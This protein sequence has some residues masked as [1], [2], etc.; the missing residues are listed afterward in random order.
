[1]KRKLVFSG[2]ML[3]FALVAVVASTYAWL[4]MQAEADVTEMDLNVTSGADLQISADGETFGYNIEIPA[5]GGLLNTVTYDTELG[6]Q[7]IVLNNDTK[8]YEY[9]SAD[10]FKPGD[11]A[12]KEG[13]LEYDLFLRADEALAVGLDV[14]LDG[15]LVIPGDTASEADLAAVKAVRIGFLIG[16]EFIIYEP[17]Q[18]ANSTFG[19]GEFFNPTSSTPFGAFANF[20]EKGTEAWTFTTDAAV[21]E[22]ATANDTVNVNEGILP[23]T[24]LLAN[25]AQQITVRIWLEGWDGDATNVAQGANFSTYLKFKTYLP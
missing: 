1:M 20:L 5:V 18:D 2:M 7:K 4:T 23:L 15:N 9:A 16:E 6:F 13:Y 24:N 11:E 22:Y 8:Q 25:E 10:V 12:G 14:S 3:V 21:N 19:T 17:Y